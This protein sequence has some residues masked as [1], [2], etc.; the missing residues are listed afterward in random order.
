MKKM[1]Y[2]GLTLFLSLPNLLVANENTCKTTLVKGYVQI[3]NF[4]EGFAQVKLD[5][6]KYAHIDRSGK[7]LPGRY[8]YASSF[9]EGLAAVQLPNGK[10]TYMDKSGKLLPNRYKYANSFQ[11][12]LAPVQLD[13]GMRAHIE[14]SGRLLP[15]RYKYASSFQEGLAPVQLE[16]GKWAYINK[17]EKPLPGRYKYANSFHEGITK[18]QLDHGKYA[19]I[20]KSGTVYNNEVKLIHSSEG[21]IAIKLDTGWWAMKDK[22]GTLL[23][24]RYRNISPSLPSGLV[25][26]IFKDGKL[27]FI[28]KSN[29]PLPDRY[30]LNSELIKW[31]FALLQRSGYTDA[32]Q[33]KYI[34]TLKKETKKYIINQAGEKVT[35]VDPNW[36]LY[37]LDKSGM[38]IFRTAPAPNNR[39]AIMDLKTCKNN[40]KGSQQPSQTQKPKDSSR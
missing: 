40:Q 37:G 33:T 6:G 19:H 22:S 38:A 39:Y 21:I 34:S 23:P 30:I 1:L 20:D 8:K 3:D 28:N 7:L 16:N 35:S 18:V 13:S 11:E 17:S 4:I 29:Q 12:G 10:W 24:G 32:L 15:G 5:N 9:Q 27:G 2:I 31:A 25:P 14:K 36:T 26:V